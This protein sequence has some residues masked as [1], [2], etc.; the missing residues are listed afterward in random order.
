[1]YY[2][3]HAQER[4]E[5]R[6]APDYVLEALEKRSLIVKGKDEYGHLVNFRIARVAKHIFWVAIEKNGN[7]LTLIKVGATED[8]YS[9]F[10]RCLL[11]Y[12]DAQARLHK[13]P[14][15]QSWQAEIT[16]DL[17]SAW[18]VELDEDTG[19]KF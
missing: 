4:I 16:Q 10:R 18:G 6:E 8:A 9:Y 14:I 5:E 12:H 3:R 2:T 7:L 1:M 19:K 11:N 15:T 17:A 13:L